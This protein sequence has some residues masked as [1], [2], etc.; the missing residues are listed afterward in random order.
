M[1]PGNP[2]GILVEEVE[3]MHKIRLLEKMEQRMGPELDSLE[4]IESEF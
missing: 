3:V 2:Q 1:R 4:V